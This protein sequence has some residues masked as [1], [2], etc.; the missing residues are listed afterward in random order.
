MN[1]R[2]LFTAAV[3]LSLPLAAAP[4]HALAASSLD[5]KI[6]TW[7]PDKDG[8]LDL[9]E[10]KKAASDKF[11]ALDTDHEGTL[12]KKELGRRVSK[13]TLLASDPDKDGTLSKDEYLGLVEQRFTAADPD[14]DGTLSVEELKTPAGKALLRLLK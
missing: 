1:I 10:V 7:D 8:T 4:V 9:T 2:H 11:D 13:V 3:L 6:K 5:A 14:K 12:D